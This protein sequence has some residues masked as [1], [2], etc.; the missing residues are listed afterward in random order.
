MR[1]DKFLMR[2]LS[3]CFSAVV[4]S[5]AFVQPASGASGA[6]VAD[7][8]SL[9]MTQKHWFYYSEP[10]MAPDDSGNRMITSVGWRFEASPHP[11]LQ[12]ELCS[13]SRTRCINLGK[14]RGQTRAFRG[15]PASEVMQL[16]FSMPG[17]GRLRKDVNIKNI[18]VIVNYHER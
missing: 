10:L 6:W 3:G 9:T 1:P 2:R 12:A 13:T 17:K 14:E 16:R 7:S 4:L 8:A 5:L 11:A 15:L 18:Q